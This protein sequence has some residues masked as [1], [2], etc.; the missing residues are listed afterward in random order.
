MVDKP[1]IFGSKPGTVRVDRRKSSHNRGYDG[2]WRKLRDAYKTEHPLCEHCILNMTVTTATE[3]DHIK[4]FN[5]LNDP[6]R[7]DPSNLQSLCRS[8]HATKTHTERIVQ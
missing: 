8:C 5:G 1:K 7:L 2:R 4:P 3:I 6:L